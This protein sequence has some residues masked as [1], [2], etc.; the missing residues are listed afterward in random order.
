MNMRIIAIAA[1]SGFAAIGAQAFE[2][3]QNPL[4]QQ[5]FMSTMPRAAVKTQAMQPIAISNG[6]TGVQASTGMADRA[7]VR[8]GARA[9]TRNGAATY[10]DYF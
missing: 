6:G 7:S 4:P 8:A 10:G 9:I 3:E 5:P 1:L 2:G